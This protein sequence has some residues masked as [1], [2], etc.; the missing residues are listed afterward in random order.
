[1]LCDFLRQNYVFHVNSYLP[2][3]SKLKFLTTNATQFH[4]FFLE[5]IHPL[6]QIINGSDYLEQRSIILHE[7]IRKSISKFYSL[8]LLLYLGR[9]RNVLVCTS[10]VTFNLFK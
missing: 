7:N 2:I 4:C 1:M 6:N 8:F 10:L 3:L 5:W 9:V